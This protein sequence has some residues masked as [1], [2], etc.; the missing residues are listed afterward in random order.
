[1]SP[2]ALLQPLL[3]TETSATRHRGR[4]SGHRLVAKGIVSHGDELM[5][6]FMAKYSP[7]VGTGGGGCVPNAITPREAASPRKG[8]FVRAVADACR[9]RR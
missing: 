4:Q 6:A 8:S 3:L 9:A 5:I 2:L 1:M 7:G